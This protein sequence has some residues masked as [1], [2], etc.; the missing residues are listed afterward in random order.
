MYKRKEKENQSPI[1]DEKLSKKKNNSKSA[2]DDTNTAINTSILSNEAVN[3]NGTPKK[4][5]RRFMVCHEILDTE[6]NYLRILKVLIEVFKKPLEVRIKHCEKN[7]RDIERDLL[8]LK[9]L[10]TLFMKITPIINAHAYI[11]EAL[12]RSLSNWNN[13]NLIGKIW[14]DFALDL[15]RVYPPYINSYDD[16]LRTLD[17][18]EF[19]KPK[20][21]EFLKQAEASPEC[22][23]NSIRD[24][25]IRPVQRIPSVLL[26]LQELF[27]RTEK[28]NPDHHWLKVAIE[29]LKGVLEKTNESRRKTDDLQQ[30]MEICQDIEDLP[31]HIISSHRQFVQSI[32]MVVIGAG[33]ILQKYKGKKIGLFL[34]NDLVEIAKSRFCTSELDSTLGASGGLNTSF[35]SGS[36]GTLPRQKSLSFLRRGASWKK[37]R[38]RYKHIEHY[39]FANFRSVEFER[40]HEVF[41]VKIRDQKADELCFFQPTNGFTL[42]MGVD[43]FE[44]LV[45]LIVSSS[46]RDIAV[47]EVNVGCIHSQSENRPEEVESI[48]KAIRIASELS[49][50]GTIRRRN[51][52]RRSI[53]NIALGAGWPHIKR[54]GSLKKSNLGDISES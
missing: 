29:Q 21:H 52:L 22:Q 26:L 39:R 17:F 36:S 46:T 53:S 48:V 49:R 37:E 38:R 42:D 47:E 5:E 31:D 18:C 16:I 2:L 54:T 44:N 6:E 30:F 8:S 14:A 25:F 41:I 1:S 15:E 28:N 13:T 27:K 43:F 11:Q 40:E 51:S 24:L 7:S 34:F 23:K 35:N 10:N 9:E 19:N 45:Q 20:F 12:Q 50:T 33:G 4:N 32:D 3:E